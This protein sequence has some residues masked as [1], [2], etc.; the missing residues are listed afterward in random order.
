MIKKSDNINWEIIQDKSSFPGPNWLFVACKLSVRECK[1]TIRE[2]SAT[3][4]LGTD[5][6]W[7][8]TKWKSGCF[9]LHSC[10]IPNLV[11]EHFLIV[12]NTHLHKAHPTTKVIMEASFYFGKLLLEYK[13][14]VGN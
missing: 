1:L 12:K 14:V 6:G 13:K 8:P 3:Y 10:N 2:Y 11:D 5:I 4:P 7:L 9:W